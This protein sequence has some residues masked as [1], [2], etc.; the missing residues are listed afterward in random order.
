MTE[1]R[2]GIFREMGDAVRTTALLFLCGMIAW[3]GYHSAS[4]VIP[5]ILNR[6]GCK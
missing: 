4:I 6:I 5:H 2:P 3:C 1:Q